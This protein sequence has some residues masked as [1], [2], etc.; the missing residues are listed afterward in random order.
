M[1]TMVKKVVDNEPPVMGFLAPFAY[2]YMRPWEKLVVLI[3]E[4]LH[5]SSYTDSINKHFYAL[6]AN[7]KYVKGSSG[8]I[9]VNDDNSMIGRTNK[10][11]QRS[12]C[13]IKVTFKE[14]HLGWRSGGLD[15]EVELLLLLG[16]DVL[17]SLHLIM[18]QHKFTINTLLH[19]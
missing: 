1:A 11:L 18:L 16:L 15:E 19:L 14:N 13:G 5:A 4:T 7:I 6:L 2:I 3:H 12:T 8:D 10:V 17:Y 9:S